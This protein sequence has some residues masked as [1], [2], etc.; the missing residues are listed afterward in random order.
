MD[1][2]LLPNEIDLLLDGEVG[3]GIEP[4][5]AHARKCSDCRAELDEARLLV[6]SLEHLPRYSA[7]PM[8]ADR[9]MAQVQIYVPWYVALG[10]TARGWIPQSRTGRA[11]AGAGGLSVATVLTLASLWVLTRLDTLVFATTLGLD[12]A[13]Q[14]IAESATGALAGVVGQPAAQL[15]RASGWFGLGLSLVLAVLMTAGAAS[16]VR[17]I[18]VRTR[19]R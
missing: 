11:L 15:L 1:R 9:V 4:L 5:R 14:G 18:V 16:L 17:G 8:L 3:F 19:G 13:R 10:D 6:R 12:R 2:H 7:S